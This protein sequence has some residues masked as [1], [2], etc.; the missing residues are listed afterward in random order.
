MLYAIGYPDSDFAAACLWPAFAAIAAAMVVTTPAAVSS[1]APIPMATAIETTRTDRMRDR[2]RQRVRPVCSDEIEHPREE[3][4]E[5][6]ALHS[7]DGPREVP[8]PLECAKSEVTVHPRTCAPG[9]RGSGERSWKGTRRS[10]RLCA[11]STFCP[12]DGR[13]AWVEERIR[14]DRRIGEGAA[15]LGG[16]LGIGVGRI[17]PRREQIEDLA[18]CGRERR[19]VRAGADVRRIA[20]ERARRP[21]SSARSGAHRRAPG[22]DGGPGCGS[23]SWRP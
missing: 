13:R 2:L 10:P 7:R 3:A 20:G 21:L 14:F 1:L 11:M 12:M 16:K 8:A 4:E 17:L 15:E 6:D 23:G 19:G 18:L 5:S 9:V 22:H